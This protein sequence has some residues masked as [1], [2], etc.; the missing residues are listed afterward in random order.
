M[1]DEEKS[2]PLEKKEVQPK[3]VI[4]ITLTDE[5]QYVNVPSVLRR[6]NDKEEGDDEP[7]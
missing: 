3:K 6:L 4:K 7:I 5:D 2:E 1:S